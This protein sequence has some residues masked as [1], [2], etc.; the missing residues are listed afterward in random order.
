MNHNIEEEDHQSDKFQKCK[1]QHQFENK[2]YYCKVNISTS[3]RVKST[4]VR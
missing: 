4:I 1:Y 3:L 2:V